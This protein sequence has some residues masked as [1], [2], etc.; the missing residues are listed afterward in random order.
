MKL[1]I[2]TLCCPD[3][4]LEQVIDAC[5]AAGVT[6]IELRGLGP[7]IDVTRLRQFTLDLEPTLALLRGRGIALPC[8]A[9]SVTLLSPSPQRW[10]EMLDEAHRYAQ[11]AARAGTPFIRVFGGALPKGAD[12]TEVL[13]VLQRHLRQIVKICKSHGARPLL[14][15]HDAWSTAAAV[16]EL[17]HE[18]DPAEAGVLWDVEHTTRSGETPGDVVEALRP[19]LHHVHLKDSIWSDGKNVPKLLGEGDLP[20]GDAVRCLRAIGYD[21]WVC[22]ETERRWHPDVAPAPEVSIPHFAAFMRGAA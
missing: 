20:V 5:A 9:T 22:L 8:F 18:F 14:E 3:W 4:S 19:Y 10:Q 11:L 1:T 2:S 17:L 16:R 21:G 6:G 15:T 7:E 12:R 13:S